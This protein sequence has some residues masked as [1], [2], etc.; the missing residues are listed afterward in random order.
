MKKNFKGFTLIELLVVAGVFVSVSTIILSIFVISL[1]GSRKSELLLTMKQNGNFA[2]SQMVKQIRYA[3]SIDTPAS[4]VPSVS[5]SSITITSLDNG[6]TTF[7][8]QVSPSTLAS[9]SAALMDTN[10]VKV[11]ACSFVCSQPTAVEPPTITISFTLL[12]KN[13]ST[14]SENTGS[15]PFTTSVT[16]RNF[17]N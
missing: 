12:P 1:R 8:C 10:Q 14:L 11:T 5:Q 6:Q 4:C 13:V 3:K 17:Q 2:M 15:I 7:S 16:M 9:N